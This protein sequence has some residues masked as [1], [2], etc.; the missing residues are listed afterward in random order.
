MSELSELI[1]EIGKH[2]IDL[3]LENEELLVENSRLK[4]FNKEKQE[5]IERLTCDSNE[6]TDLVSDICND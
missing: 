6:P 2:V 5:F 4:R 3:L 1:S